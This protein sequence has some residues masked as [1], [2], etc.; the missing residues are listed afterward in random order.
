M[1]PEFEVG[2][3]P[4][5]NSVDHHR[6]VLDIIHKLY[7]ERNTSYG[8]SFHKMYEELGIISGVTQ[9]AHKY[10][11]LIGLAKQLNQRRA[12][13]HLSDKT[14]DTLYDLANYSILLAME[15]EREYHYEDVSIMVLK[16]DES[17]YDKSKS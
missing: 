3:N 13:A 14:I 4:D 7:K 2:K 10:N 15:L 9:I 12:D 16:D 8:D 17:G 6:K 1:K 5:Y 11:R